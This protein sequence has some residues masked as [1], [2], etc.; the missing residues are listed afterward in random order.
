MQDGVKVDQVGVVGRE[1]AVED[2][3]L[4][5]RVEPVGVL[6]H[7]GPVAHVPDLVARARGYDLPVCDAGRVQVDLDPATAAIVAEPVLLCAVDV[8]DQ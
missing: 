2:D 4:A 1:E 6:G 3:L 7:P 5:E 8:A